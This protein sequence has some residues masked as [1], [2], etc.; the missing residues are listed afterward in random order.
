MKNWN[1][2]FGKVRRR[3]IEQ[4]KWCFESE[5]RNTHFSYIVGT[6][7]VEQFVSTPELR[8]DEA[9][10]SCMGRPE[11]LNDRG[12]GLRAPIPLGWAPDALTFLVAKSFMLRC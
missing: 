11:D 2:S 9:V 12:G 1:G 10:E 4:Q 6:E 8:S 3:A 5:F 7:G